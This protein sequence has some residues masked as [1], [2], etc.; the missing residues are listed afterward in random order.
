MLCLMS[1]SHHLS[2]KSP[3]SEILPLQNHSRFGRWHASSH[4]LQS[5]SKTKVLRTLRCLW[6]WLTTVKHDGKTGVAESLSSE[7][8]GRPR[9]QISSS[10]PR[11]SPVLRDAKSPDQCF[12]PLTCHTSHGQILKVCI[13]VVPQLWT[14][15]LFGVI[16]CPSN[17]GG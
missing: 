1:A 12:Q 9:W 2:G 16:W 15:H 3:S 5:L 10:I 6:G 13:L 14:P 17:H 4:H 8:E 11:T 7:L